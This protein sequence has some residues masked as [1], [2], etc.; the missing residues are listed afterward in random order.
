MYTR[1][2]AHTHMFTYASVC[3]RLVRSGPVQVIYTGST[4]QRNVSA[5]SGNFAAQRRQTKTKYLMNENP[6]RGVS[7]GECAGVGVQNAAQP[8]HAG[9]GAGALRHDDLFNAR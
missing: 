6:K 9:A 4:R 1:A 5:R 7:T 2:H 3:T 8:A